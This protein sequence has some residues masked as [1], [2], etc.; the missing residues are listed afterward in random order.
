MPK[1]TPNLRKLAARQ[2]LIL[3]LILGGIA[4]FFLPLIP[5]GNGLAAQFVHIGLQLLISVLLI[6][7]VGLLLSAEGSHPIVIIL[8]SIVMVVPL[9][10]LLILL[11]VNDSATRTLKAAGLRVGFMGVSKA[12]VERLLAPG[13]CKT[14]GYSLL[15]NTSGKCPECGT[16]IRPAFCGNCGYRIAEITGNACPQCGLIIQSLVT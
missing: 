9:V 7:C 14:C 16:A 15:G 10:N 6:V 8:T 11:R 13:V 2:R 1:R 3:W 12:E 4:S 5:I